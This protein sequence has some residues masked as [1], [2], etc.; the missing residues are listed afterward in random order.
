MNKS[1]QGDIN[2]FYQSR[3]RQEFRSVSICTPKPLFPGYIFAR[4]DAATMS[5]NIS[6]ARGVHSIVGVGDRP[7]PVDD[8][9][10]SLVMHGE[11]AVA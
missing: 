7:A 8:A 10:I 11:Q 1:L 6:Y 5:H 9:V 3:R 2:S 4:F